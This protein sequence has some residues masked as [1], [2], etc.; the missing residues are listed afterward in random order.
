MATSKKGSNEASGP[1]RASDFND[2]LQ[3]VPG[4][5]AMLHVI[6]YSAMAKNALR[7]CEFDALLEASKEAG[8]ILHDSGT[9]IDCSATQVWPEDAERVNT[10]VKEKYDEFPKIAGGFKEFV[11]NARASF[12]ANR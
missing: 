4:H 3:N 7:E 8:K 10:R 11:E 12:A 5:V 6:N 2:A 1:Q 9:A